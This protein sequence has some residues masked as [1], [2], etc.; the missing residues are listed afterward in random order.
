MTNLNTGQ[1]INL[2][3]QIMKNQNLSPIL[4]QPV[5]RVMLGMPTSGKA[6]TGAVAHSEDDSDYELYDLFDEFVLED[7]MF[8]DEGE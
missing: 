2:E 4:N 5:Q 7:L 8:G 6:N 1:L 3:A